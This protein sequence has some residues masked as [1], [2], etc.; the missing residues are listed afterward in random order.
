VDRFQKEIQGLGNLYNP[1]PGDLPVGRD[2]YRIQR[3]RKRRLVFHH[4]GKVPLGGEKGLRQRSLA[5]EGGR[6][7]SRDLSPMKAWRGGGDPL[8]EAS[9]FH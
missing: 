6:K 7:K 9:Q 8:G 5:R 2:A 1:I 4:F 3:S